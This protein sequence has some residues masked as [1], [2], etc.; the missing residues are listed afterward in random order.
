MTIIEQMDMAFPGVPGFKGQGWSTQE[1]AMVVRWL[2]ATPAA[3]DQAMSTARAYPENPHTVADTL[4]EK[5]VPRSELDAIVTAGG[6]PAKVNWLE[7]AHEL[8]ERRDDPQPAQEHAGITAQVLDL[9]AAAPY[10]GDSTAETAP[11]DF[12][13]VVF[14]SPL[15]Q[16]VV[17]TLNPGQ[18]I[19]SEIHR[20]G[21]QLFMVLSGTGTATLNLVPHDIGPGSLIAAPAGTRHNVTAGTGA[22]LRLVTVYSPPQ[23]PPGTVEHAKGGAADEASPPGPAVA[24][25]TM[26]GDATWEHEARDTRGRWFHGSN[27]VFQPG[28]IIDPSKA[29]A[30]N[31]RGSADDR[32]YLT[33]EVKT[34]K[35]YA[36]MMSGHNPIL[37]KRPGMSG[38]PHVYEVE[39]MG[40]IEPDYRPGTARTPGKVRIVREVPQPATVSLAA[41]AAADDPAAAMATARHLHD[42]GRYLTA[43]SGHLDAAR[44]AGAGD[45]D[46]HLG[47]CAASLDGAHASAHDLA[48]HLRSHYPAEA[49]DLDALCTTIGLAR[50]VSDQAK[51][52]TTAHL[53]QTICNHLGHTIEHVKAMGADKTPKVRDFNGDHAR[54]HL[55]GAIEHAG[56]LTKHLRDN[57]PEEAKHLAELKGAPASGCCGGP[58]C[59]G[60]CC[61]GSGGCQCGPVAVSAQA[62]R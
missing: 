32:F 62:S 19:G 60:G 26:A 28:D 34:A 16:M 56:K 31:M 51:T 46:G 17:M 54:T 11:G 47:R 7:V 10:T 22:P 21:D 33:S 53:T 49:R 9:A 20:D 39:P 6:D 61:G 18:Q 44:E 30:K 59:A 29:H 36:D 25:V 23:H 37:G 48:A 2:F 13:R 5:I 4:H 14:T 35:T 24:A 8:I 41:Q 12:R 1:T 58:C 55:D 15:S 27:R 45:P 38:E 43:A 40:P 52:A 50:S 42:T 3:W 57:Y